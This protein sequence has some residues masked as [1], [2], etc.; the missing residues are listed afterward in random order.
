MPW[1][2]CP[3]VVWREARDARGCLGYKTEAEA[4]AE[5]SCEKTSEKK[6]NFIVLRER[7]R[8]TLRCAERESL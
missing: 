7:V 5:K 3:F 8:K 1:L 4:E 2:A 6:K